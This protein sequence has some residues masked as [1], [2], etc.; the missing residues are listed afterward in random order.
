MKNKTKAVYDKYN[1]KWG[2][3][4]ISIWVIGFILWYLI[5][6]I[7]SLV[8]TT[9]DF[10]LATPDKN[11]FVGLQNWGRIFLDP[12]VLPS[13][14]KVFSFAMISLPITFLFSFLVSVLMNTKNL[15]G[16]SVFRALFY[17]PTMVP[18]VAVVLIWQG[19]LNNQ[20]GWINLFLE[21]VLHIK[22]IGADGIR[23][24]NDPKIIYFTYTLFGLWGI[25]NSMLIFIAGLQ[26]VPAQ[27]YEA[28]TVDGAG[29]FRQ[30]VHITV[31]IITPII[32]YN[33]TIALI[34]LL[35]YFLVPYVLNNGSGAPEGKTN[36]LMVY[37][38]RQSFNYF[39]MGYGA[40]LA[41]MIFLIAFVLTLML[42]WSSK[43]WV[44]YGGSDK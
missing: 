29:P 36:F 42:F 24:L 23:W 2:Y 44:Y 18:L 6:M 22:A 7:A 25:G 5:P 37:F 41:W 1:I 19:V 13:I 27:L 32:F 16:R 33:L 12:E 43:K 3:F 10:N 40:T 21:N 39:N 38:Y 34:G 8:F 15:M 4:F 20:A 17:L 9:L 14:Y 30:M 31:P 26:N 35:Q 11:Q 28:A